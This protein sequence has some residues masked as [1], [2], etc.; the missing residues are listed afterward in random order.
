VG[1][2]QQFAFQRVQA[3]YRQLQHRL[4]G[5]FGGQRWEDADEIV[6][7]MMQENCQPSEATLNVIINALTPKGL[8][9][10]VIEPLEKLSNH[11]CKTNVVTSNS[12]IN[13]FSEQGHVI[14]PWNF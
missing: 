12:V 9:Q 7:E 6:T 2:P 14:V 8:L 3:E 13:G 4:E 11:G 1:V 5:I 10:K